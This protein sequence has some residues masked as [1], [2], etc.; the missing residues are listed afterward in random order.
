MFLFLAF[1]NTGPFYPGFYG[2]GEGARI[3]LKPMHASLL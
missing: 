2:I 3:M 1:A